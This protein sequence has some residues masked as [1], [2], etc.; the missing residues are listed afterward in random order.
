MGATLS[1]DDFEIINMIRNLENARCVLSAKAAAIANDSIAVQE[2]VQG[3]GKRGM[4]TFLKK[5]Y[6]GKSA[7]F[8]VFSGDYQEYYITILKKHYS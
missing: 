3:V 7:W 8:S 1:S 5:S 2:P 6:Y 4:P